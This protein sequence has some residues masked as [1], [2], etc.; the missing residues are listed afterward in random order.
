MTQ[1]SYMGHRVAVTGAPA[2]LEGLIEAPGPTEY[3]GGKVG[4]RFG[5][6]AGA[7]SL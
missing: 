7:L 6:Q 4:G 3:C 5:W 1:D 2:V